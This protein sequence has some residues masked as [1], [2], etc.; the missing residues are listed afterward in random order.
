MASRSIAANCRKVICIGRNYADHIKEL[1]NVRPKKPFFFLKPP[2]SILE[3]GQGPV[4]RPKGTNLHYEVE[5]ALIMGRKVQDLPEDDETG[6]LDAVAGYAVGIDMTARDVQEEAKKKGY[7][8]TTAKGFDTF[9]PV[10]RYIAKSAV[11]DPHDVELWLTVNGKERQRDSTALMLFRIPRILSEISRV[12]RLE[13]GDVV[14]TG[15]PKG[16]G[17]VEVGDV[18]RAGVSVGGKEVE[19]G[20]IEVGVEEKG[21]LYVFEE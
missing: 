14:L 9:L 3:P 7:P 1:N 15:T 4:L 8:W 16:V 10:S 5:L 2:S 17:R 6:A 13:E 19:G 18:M 20:G 21:G 12:M 11:P